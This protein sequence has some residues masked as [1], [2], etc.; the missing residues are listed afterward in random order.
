M[1]LGVICLDADDAVR[2]W[3][4]YATRLLGWSLADVVGR[5]LPVELRV[6]RTLQQHEKE[7][8]S[9]A[10]SLATKSGRS[11][12]VRV[13]RALW[14]NADGVEGTL[15]ALQQDDASVQPL[16]GNLLKAT[17][18]AEA[19]REEARAARRFRELLEAAPDAIIETDAAGRIV[20]LNRGAERMFGYQREELLGAGVE[21]LVPESSRAGHTRHRE[22][23]R[24]RPSTRPMGIGL[25]L[26][27]RKKDGSRFPV[28]ISLSPVESEE[29]F[30]VTAIIRDV[31]ERTQ[32]EDA[33]RAVQ[34]KYTQELADRN[35]ELER[36]NRLKS[37]FL[38]SMSHELRT[39]L[40][41]VIG[42]SELLGEELEGPLNEKQK[43]FVSHIHRDSLHLL[44]L[45]NDVL[46][47]SKI[48]SGRLTLRLE[49]VDFPAVL[50]ESL[51]S[52][53][54]QA[55][56]KS[57]ILETDIASPLRLEA[58]RLRIKQVLVNLLSNAVKFTPEGGR[59]SVAARPE[60]H[61]AVISVKDTGIGIPKS[62]H[63]SIFDKFYQ[64]S[65]TTKGVREGTGLGLAITK[66][67]V[68]EHG[69]HLSLESEPGKGTVFTFSMPLRRE[70]TAT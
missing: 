47:L 58:D 4:R 37:E 62:E 12:G 27:G 69:G 13:Q 18:Q 7:S 60:G 55:H 51:G 34:E 30:R 32:A 65:A 42:F 2:V 16:Q 28:E 31:S 19:A 44:E 40:H 54:P 43:R 57:Q 66:H 52:I 11:I 21:V 70:R 1:Q 61:H 15:I 68:E 46:D 67:L 49:T 45:I 64:V 59:I 10:I 33:L 48:E 20:L 23:Y 35:R 25:T 41:T 26:A 56:A 14:R 63:E 9:P 24:A 8:P 5:P 6:L 29:G 39:P 17:A 53:R 22:N 36:A 50:E 3:N 38:A